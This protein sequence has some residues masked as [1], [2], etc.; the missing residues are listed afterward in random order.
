MKHQK[1]QCDV[2]AETPSEPA[3]T[4]TLC[5][6]VFSDFFFFCFT[7]S[8]LSALVLHRVPSRPASANAAAAAR[9]VGVPVHIVLVHLVL[10]YLIVLVVLLNHAF[11]TAVLATLHFSKFTLQ[12][13]NTP[14]RLCASLLGG[15]LRL[16]SRLLLSLLLGLLLLLGL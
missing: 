7:A 15:I 10:V 1:Q 9:L 2:A 14:V 12:L 16:L 13:R 4:I 6:L 8:V 11:G 5:L 3:M